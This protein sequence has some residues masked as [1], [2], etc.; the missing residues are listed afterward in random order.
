MGLSMVQWGQ[1]NTDFQYNNHRLVAEAGAA[2]A[3]TRPAN[4]CLITIN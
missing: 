4:F 2:A 1:I 3:V